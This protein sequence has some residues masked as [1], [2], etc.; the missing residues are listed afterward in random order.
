MP[1][2]GVCKALDGQEVAV[3]ENWPA[4]LPKPSPLQATPGCVC[5]NP[6]AAMFCPYG[7][8]MECHYPMNCEQAQCSHLTRYREADL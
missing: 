7:H 1:Q 2:Y 6:M 4:E 5:D 8:M 3:P